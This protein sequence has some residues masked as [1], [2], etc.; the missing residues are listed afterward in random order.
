M[1]L[2]T[3]GPGAARHQAAVDARLGIFAGAD[4]PVVLGAVPFLALPAED[5]LVK[6]QGALGIVGADFEVYGTWHKSALLWVIKVMGKLVS[7]C[8]EIKLLYCTYVQLS[9]SRRSFVA[10]PEEDAGT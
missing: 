4:Q 3:G 9:S 1:V 7:V 2:T 5:R 8:C 10:G 6:V